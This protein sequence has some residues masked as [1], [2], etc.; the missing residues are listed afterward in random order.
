M[1]QSI[2]AEMDF[3]TAKAVGDDRRDRSIDS[4]DVGKQYRRL[5]WSL[6]SKS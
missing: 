6:Q 5:R 4:L 2:D 1:A 3:E